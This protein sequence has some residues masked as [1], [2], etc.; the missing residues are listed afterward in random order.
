MGNDKILTLVPPDIGQ[1]YKVASENIIRTLQGL[2][3]VDLV[4]V[5]RTT[6][7][8]LQLF[9]TGGSTQTIAELERAKFFLL[10][11]DFSD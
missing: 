6:D 7:G 5:A 4:A 2:D 3:I 11:G 1:D 9:S 10:A 8:E